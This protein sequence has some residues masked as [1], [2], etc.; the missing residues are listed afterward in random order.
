MGEVNFEKE[1]WP[2]A[3]LDRYDMIRL[4]EKEDLDIQFDFT[5]S[6]IELREAIEKELG[7]WDGDK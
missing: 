1:V 5:T 3:E 4:I 7:L 2:I 6:N